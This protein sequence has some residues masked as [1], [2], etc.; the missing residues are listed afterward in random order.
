MKP[1]LSAALAASPLI[2][3]AKASNLQDAI[4]DLESASRAVFLVLTAAMLAIGLGLAPLGI[5]IY[6][7][8]VKGVY[9][10][11]KKWKI[12]AFA[13][14]AGGFVFLLAGLLG[15]A[16]FFLMPSIIRGLI[17]GG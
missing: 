6:L 14:G 13:A 8:K 12:G 15:L 3:L 16:I 17:A 1:G 11:A 10:P 2:A 9:N 5:F 7:R 4:G